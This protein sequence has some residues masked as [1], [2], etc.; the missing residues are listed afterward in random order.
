MQIGL[1]IPLS[2]RIGT[3]AGP[4]IVA[5]LFQTIINQLDTAMVGRLPGATGIDGQ[6]GI[7]LSLPLFWALGGFL[8]AIGIGTQAITARRIGELH[9]RQAGKALT[10]S[11]TIA[12]LSS[13]TVATAGYFLSPL[14]FELMSPNPNVVR[15]GSAYCSIRMIGVFTMVTTMSY[16]AFFDGIG[17]THVHMVAS[18]VMN[19]L[20]AG[21]NFLLIFGLWG[22]PRLEVEGAAIASV[23]STYAGL[24]MMVLWS[25][26]PTYLRKYRYYRLGNLS[27]GISWQIVRLSV[28]SGLATVFVMTGFMF[29]LWVIGNLEP[30]PKWLEAASFVPLAGPVVAGVEAL[31]PD[32]ATAA[33]WN[34]MSFLMLIFIT[35]I[36]FGTATATLVSQSLG[37][38]KPALAER[39]GW[40]SVKIGMFVMGAVGIVMIIHPSMFMR[41][42]TDKPEVIAVALP[43]MRMI[44]SIAALISA[45]MILVQALFGAGN[46]RFVM[47]AEM[48]LHLGCLIPLCYLL[49]M[50]L[51]LGMLG[52]WLAACIYGVLLSSIMA[53]KFLE[54]KWKQIQ[55]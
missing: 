12:V 21:L 28:P 8:S 50:V 18:I 6:A 1:D 41:I 22:F 55:I 47:I 43:S 35:S 30:G 24:G 37:A 27:R 39:Y 32:L 7:G 34:M 20:N 11:L 5:M 25:L 3:L 38:R 29:F 16:K 15:L 42:F 46:T 40:E 9:P 26:F 17:K 10:N 33:S 31:Q 36:A 48:I 51:E 13:A 44:G 52:C 14:F 23:V 19:L 49:G 4:V 54:G 53:W 2:K 45:G